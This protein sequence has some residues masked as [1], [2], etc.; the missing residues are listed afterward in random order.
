LSGAEQPSMRARITSIYSHHDNIVAPQASGELPGARNLAFG[1]VGHV[2]LG[3][4]PRVLAAVL[5]ELD[6]LRE[7]VPDAPCI[8]RGAAAAV[9][10]H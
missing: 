9:Q 1:G 5:G 10:H 8:D 4:N 7:E 6:A 3:R 2:A